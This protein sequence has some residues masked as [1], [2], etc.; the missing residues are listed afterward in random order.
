MPSVTCGLQSRF[1]GIRQI[2]FLLTQERQ[3]GIISI[4]TNYVVATTIMLF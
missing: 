3:R 4:I 2:L 1:L